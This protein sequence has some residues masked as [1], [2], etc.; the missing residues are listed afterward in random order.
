MKKSN[1]SIHYIKPIEEYTCFIREERSDGML[2]IVLSRVFDV[3]RRNVISMIPG[4][5][6]KRVWICYEL[7]RPSENGWFTLRL[8]FINGDGK[9]IRVGTP[10]LFVELAY[11]L[12]TDV[13]FP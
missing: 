10:S 12:K 5:A 13:L 9:M 2:G 8:R 7:V 6:G 11:L 4:N 3:N 1:A